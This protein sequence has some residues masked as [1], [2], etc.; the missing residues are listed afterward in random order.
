MILILF[1]TMIDS[2]YILCIKI[3]NFFMKHKNDNICLFLVK[4]PAPESVTNAIFELTKNITSYKIV[5]N[6]KCSIDY[7][8][9]QYFKV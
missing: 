2:K 8:G 1:Y 3:L 4:G 5:P 6:L 7:C 9:L